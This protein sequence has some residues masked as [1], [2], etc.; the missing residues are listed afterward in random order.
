MTKVK[1][2]KEEIY[3]RIS[4]GLAILIVIAVVMIGIHESVSLLETMAIE[5]GIR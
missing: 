4:L 5:Y 1:M 3:G 2:T